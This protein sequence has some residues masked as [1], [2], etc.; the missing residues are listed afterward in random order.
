MAER[1]LLQRDDDEESLLSKLGT[2]SP[3]PRVKFGG[4]FC[5]VEGAYENKT[6]NFESF[7]PNSVRRSAKTRFEDRCM[8]PADLDSFSERG[9]EISNFSSASTTRTRVENSST[10]RGQTIVFPSGH[11]PERHGEWQV[12]SHRQY[13]N[14][15]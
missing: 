14:H 5:N 11:K 9:S 4:M 3:K 15:T 1:K 8:S 7:S 13:R 6:L 2:D 12:G 10:T